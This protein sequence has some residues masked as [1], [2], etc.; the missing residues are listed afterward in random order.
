MIGNREDFL[1]P[2]GCYVAVAD[3]EKVVGYFRFVGGWFYDLGSERQYL[4]L[5][6]AFSGKRQIWMFDLT[7]LG[8]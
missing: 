8:D 6:E 7:A 2:E 4:R 5:S 3:T 1:S